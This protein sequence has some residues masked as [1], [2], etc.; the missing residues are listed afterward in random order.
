MVVL[1][2]HLSLTTTHASQIGSEAHLRPPSKKCHRRTATGC[3]SLSELHFQITQKWLALHAITNR[4]SALPNE[5]CMPKIVETHIP[6]LL[7]D[8]LFEKYRCH[9]D[10]A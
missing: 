6:G 7:Y 3:R 9:R 8:R 5:Q 1:L 10:S 2:M 4:A